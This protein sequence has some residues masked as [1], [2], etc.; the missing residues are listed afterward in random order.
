MLMVRR[1]QV[2]NGG[3]Q[4]S[5]DASSGTV[6]ARLAGMF[7]VASVRD[8]MQSDWRMVGLYASGYIRMARCQR[9]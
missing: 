4:I 5:G 7:C 9:I 8:R 2:A 1:S 6:A 3:R